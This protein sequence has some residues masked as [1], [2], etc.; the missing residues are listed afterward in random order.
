MEGRT[1][2]R[3]LNEAIVEGAVGVRTK[4]M[5]VTATT[6]GPVGVRHRRQRD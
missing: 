5:T 1:G 4:L 3:D 6:A 2:V